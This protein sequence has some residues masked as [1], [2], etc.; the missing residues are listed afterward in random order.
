MARNSG[1]A[2]SISETGWSPKA[3]CFSSRA[4]SPGEIEALFEELVGPTEAA[5]FWRQYR[6][7]YLTKADIA[8][9]RRCGFNSVRIPLHY[10]FFL[11]DAGFDSLDPMIDWCR[12]DSLWV[13]LD[14]HCALGGQTGT[15]IDDSRGY[16]WLYD[17]AESQELPIRIWQRIARH[18]RDEP[19]VLGYDLLNEPIPHFPALRRYNADLEPLYKR[20]TAGIRAVDPDHIVIVG[21]A[22]WDTNFGVFGAPFDRQPVY[23]LHKYWMPPGR[24][25]IQ[26]YLDFRDRYNV[27]IWCGETGENNDGWIRQFVQTLERNDVGWCFWPYKKMEKASCVVSIVKPAFWDEA[28]V[29]AKLSAG[30]RRR[31]KAYCGAAADPASAQ[32]S[33]RAACKCSFRELPSQSRLR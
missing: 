31:G 9:I 25:S 23:Q 21:G 24:E 2:A 29:F 10:K 16:P 8:F 13:I 15:N 11:T 27:P 5:S 17:S 30:K 7:S 22:Q 14:M 4:Q 3:I 1:C 32:V 12:E 33:R 18:Y 28:T 26:P 20:V 19:I 6:K